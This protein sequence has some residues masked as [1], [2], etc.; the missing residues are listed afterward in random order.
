M[1]I[2]YMS[3][4]MYF[5]PQT[6]LIDASLILLNVF[7]IANQIKSTYDAMPR[8]QDKAVVRAG[9]PQYYRLIE[10][11]EAADTFHI[12]NEDMGEVFV[13]RNGKKE[14]IP[15]PFFKIECIGKNV[16]TYEQRETNEGLMVEIDCTRKDYIY[17]AFKDGPKEQKIDKENYMFANRR[18][19][20]S[21]NLLDSLMRNIEQLNEENS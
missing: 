15:L 4:H 8:I 11:A 12:N 5:Q 6:R 3:L 10:I 9:I 18:E 17:L 20:R 13:N 21:M 16:T 19:F 1:I 14:F 2:A 7:S